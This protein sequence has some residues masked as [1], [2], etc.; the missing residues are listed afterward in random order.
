[1][2]FHLPASF[3]SIFMWMSSLV[4][5]SAWASQIATKVALRAGRIAIVIVKRGYCFLSL[6]FE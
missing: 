5:F 6:L 1:M 3:W 4:L 2:S